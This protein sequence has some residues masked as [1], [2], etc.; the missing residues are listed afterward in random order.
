MKTINTDDLIRSIA[1]LDTA[2]YPII[3]MEQLIVQGDMAAAVI[4]AFLNDSSEKAYDDVPLLVVLGEIRTAEAIPVL[5]QSMGRDN[6]VVA[7]VAA[8]G[9]AKIGSQAIEPLKALIADP[10]TAALV[11]LRAYGALGMMCLPQTRKYLRE[12]LRVEPLYGDV[13][14][15]A[16][17]LSGEKEDAALI[18]AVYE[19]NEVSYMNPEFEESIYYCLHPQEREQLPTVLDWRIRYRRLPEL[20]H[21]IQIMPLDIMM[22][23]RYSAEAAHERGSGWQGPKKNLEEIAAREKMPAERCESCGEVYETRIGIPVCSETALSTALYQR[24]VIQ[25]LINAD[26]ETVQQGFDYLDNFYEASRSDTDGSRKEK[27]EQMYAA[28]CAT[29]NYLIT[30]KIYGLAAGL[31]KIDAIIRLMDPEALQSHTHEHGPD[32]G[33]DDHEH[34]H[35]VG[36]NDPC[37]CG[38]G[39]KFKKCCGLES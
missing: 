20:D 10:E 5:L 1:T 29:L 31:E 34:T 32:C 2:S 27:T 21:S 13:I 15:Y 37:P 33:C 9:L 19:K 8:E 7:M 4:I 14:A 36:R 3:E 12:R 17:S 30:R 26:C 35:E 6:D 24:A 38:S 25:E 23:M 18:H 39:K 22:L 16:L 28:G 11:R